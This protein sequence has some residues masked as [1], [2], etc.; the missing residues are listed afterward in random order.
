MVRAALGE[1]L[2]AADAYERSKGR[3]TATELEPFRKGKRSRCAR[4][5]SAPLPRANAA[6]RAEAPFVDRERERAVLGA[7]V[8]PV[9]MGFGTLVEPHR[10]P[11]NRQVPARRRARAVHRH[12]QP[13]CALRAIRVVDAIPRLQAAASIGPRGRRERR[14]RRLAKPC[15]LTS[16]LE[17]VDPDLGPWAPLFAAPL[18]VDVETTP[19]VE[20][21][22]PSFRRARLHGVVGSL[23]SSLSSPTLMVFEDVQW[24]DEAF[25]L[26]RHR[27]RCRR[28]WLVH[29]AKADRRR[30]SRRGHD[31]PFPR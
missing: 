7:S 21:P 5:R 29:D 28:T 22:E 4:S 27:R 20:E 3:F 16:R 9:R 18:D 17:Q 30:V 13:D 24:M 2:V 14:G 12:G 6:D 10:R 31:R 1:I 19:E 23:G 8:A 26:L 25:D 11:R 15:V